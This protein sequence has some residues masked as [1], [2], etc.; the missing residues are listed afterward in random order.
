MSRNIGDTRCQEC[1][2]VV[3][4]VEPARK[5][6]EADVRRYSEQFLGMTVANARCA[7]CGTP[8]LAWYE[9]PPYGFHAGQPVRCKWGTDEPEII[10]LSY[11]HAFNDEPSSDGRDAPIDSVERVRA[12]RLRRARGWEGTTP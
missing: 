11:R 4:A 5:A 1:D 2:G 10:D 3:L 7:D 8:Y 6:T 9:Y 12:A